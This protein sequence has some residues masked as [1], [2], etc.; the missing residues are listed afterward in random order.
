MKQILQYI[1]NGDTKV[2]EVSPPV[3]KNGGVLVKNL[4]SLISVGTEKMV[5]DIAKKSYIGKAK[6]RPDQVK[7]VIDKV[8]LE[9][10]WTTYKKVMDKLDEPMGLG[11]SSVG[12]V[13]AVADDVDE[14]KVGDF[15][16][17]A[18]GS[19]AEVTF[20]PKNLVIK[21]KDD[22]KLR[23][24]AY[25]TLGSIAMQGIRQADVTLG[26]NVAVIGL[27]LVGQIT[28]QLLKAAGCR[29]IGIDVNEERVRLAEKCG[30]DEVVNSKISDPKI[31]VLNFTN[32]YGAD[33]VVLTASSKDN[34]ITELA[35]EIAR[36]RA[37]ISSVGAVKMDIPRKVFYEKELD[38]RLSRSYGPGRYDRQYEE[39]G[40]DYPIGYVRW[41]EKRNMQE[42]ARLIQDG[43]VNM[44]L[45]TTHIFD[46][47]E[48]EKAYE[49]VTE[50]PR[51]EDF[52]GVL[53]QYKQNQQ[54]RV[55]N[56]KIENKNKVIKKESKIGI[57]LIGAGN[58]AKV[59]MMPLLSKV[60][61]LNFVGVVS[62]KGISGNV[63]AKK[64][65]FDYATSDYLELLEDDSVNL[66]IIATNHNL[67]SQMVCDC[68]EK[69]KHVYVEKPLAIDKAGLE[70]IIDS[71][72]LPAAIGSQVIV[73]FNR[74]YALHII[75]AQ[76]VMDSKQPMMVNYRINA[77]YIPK[78]HW[79]N[80]INIGGGRIIGECCHF[81]D[82]IGYLVNSEPDRI[83][84]NSAV[85]KSGDYIDEDNVII[86]I[87]YKNGSIGSIMYTSLGDKSF[88]KERIEIY[89][90]SSVFVIDDFIKGTYTKNGR[91]KKINL[92]KQDKGFL[93]LY[94]NI[95]E[96]LTSGSELMNFENLCMT[97]ST[98]F[99]VLNQLKKGRTANDI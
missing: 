91:T 81:I 84:S 13:V 64:Y 18:G 35:G 23:Y 30:A 37:I 19:H 88:P 4:Y 10:L 41:T 16:A 15:V 56:T 89:Q 50:N 71:K 36:D 8:K 60:Q 45:L 1:K 44:E 5:V 54:D 43:L 53:F 62:A 79:V 80:D 51:K 11:Y 90:N 67:H 27:G 49:L 72:N 34:A 69:G 73:G 47:E 86:T 65:G 98:T 59:T 68:L 22:D 38:L 9:G 70:H 55:F 82:L 31:A 76:K 52:L 28:V 66:A 46:L 26:E 96:S 29:V 99:E 6:E 24:Y 40:H 17:C 85:L 33:K 48:A 42:F 78:S 2:E 94:E 87:Q 32:G 92:K 95:V 20:T 74:R 57:G 63:I 12:Q 39:K 7:Q 21:V 14:F 93:R 83:S 75:E 3:L 25:V 61:D 97:T 77:G 58:F